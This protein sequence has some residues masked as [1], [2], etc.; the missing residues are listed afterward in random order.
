MN[1]RRLVV[2]ISIAASQSGL[3]RASAEELGVAS[4][5]ATQSRGRAANGENL[6]PNAFTAAHRTLPFGTH[7]LVTNKK[8]GRSVMVTIT[9][10]G[11]FVRGRIIDVTPVAARELGFSGLTQVSVQAVNER[12][13]MP[14]AP[15]GHHDG[16][17]FLRS[18]RVIPIAAAP[19]GSDGS[20]KPADAEPAADATP[21]SADAESPTPAVSAKKMR[22]H[23][24]YV[25]RRERSAYSLSPS[26]M[27]YY[28][29]V[30]YARAWWPSL[31]RNVTGKYGR[32][33]VRATTWP[34]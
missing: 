7:V 32:Q 9:D 25:Q 27:Q 16:P 8:N 31:G 28:Y 33:T 34:F 20:A 2:L 26:Y 30:G 15:I 23:S 19:E 22:T 13:V 4:V 5:Y 1:G 24:S 3:V 6:N 12:P 29:Q 18:E 21:A 10:R 14:A 11:P 17:A